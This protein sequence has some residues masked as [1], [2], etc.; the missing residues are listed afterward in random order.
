VAAWRETFKPQATTRRRN[1]R[2]NIFFRI[3]KI[4]RSG[5]AALRET[6]KPQAKA[7]Q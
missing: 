5:V 2:K 6:F 4:S 3:I 7:Q 1:E